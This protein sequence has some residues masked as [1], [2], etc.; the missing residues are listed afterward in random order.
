MNQTISISNQLDSVSLV[1][2]GG[3]KNNSVVSEAGQS[4]P[5]LAII[6]SMLKQMGE[7]TVLAEELLTISDSLPT[8]ENEDDVQTAFAALLSAF[9]QTMELPFLQQEEE[10]D[11]LNT[12]PNMLAE[13]KSLNLQELLQNQMPFA[14]MHQKMQQTMATQTENFSELLPKQEK[15]NLQEE[16]LPNKLDF[17]D[18]Q[19]FDSQKQSSVPANLEQKQESIVVQ[20]QFFDAIGTVKRKLA[21][22]KMT[23]EST[24]K[25][26]TT[27][28]GSVVGENATVHNG[29]AKALQGQNGIV[30]ET[31]LV[32]Q[33]ANEITH[34]VAKGK[35]EFTMTLKPEALG[36]ITVRFIE[37][38]GKK[39]LKIFAANSQTA[40]LLNQELSALREAV[41]PMQIEVHEVM[42][43]APE[44]ADQPFFQHFDMSGHQFSQ[45]QREIWHPQKH[46]GQ[47]QNQ[48]EDEFA[49]ESEPALESTGMNIYV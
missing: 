36:E 31:P 16:N 33:L 29:F 34:H 47:I 23:G 22:A 14:E 19:A 15:L 45:Q 48:A 18:V 49:I 44:S 35:N 26:D 7:G 40:Q 28:N 39:T 5:F 9:P 8:K 2:R 1:G 27:L 38:E 25:E 37:E 20:R 43:K 12:V 24:V 11:C 6:Q 42:Q 21:E 17:S 32:E 3:R 10:S 30:Q 46:T 4:D 13:S 41:K